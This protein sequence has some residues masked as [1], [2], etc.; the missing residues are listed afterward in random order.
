[1]WMMDGEEKVEIGAYFVYEYLRTYTLWSL[2]DA[3]F[4]F[5]C[6]F[7]FYEDVR[8]GVIVKFKK[9]KSN[10]RFWYLIKKETWFDAQW[11]NKIWDW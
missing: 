11:N 8:F 7:K 6:D 9:K 10:F 3:L 5:H 2:K 4:L 1:M